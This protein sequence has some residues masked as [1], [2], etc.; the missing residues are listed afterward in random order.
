MK[1]PSGTHEETETHL[2]G[3]AL[4]W[5]LSLPLSPLSP[6]PL[7]L[8]R[9]CPL[10]R[11]PLFL[12]LSWSLRSRSSLRLHAKAHAANGTESAQGYTLVHTQTPGVQWST[13]WTLLACCSTGIAAAKSTHALC[14][15][16]RPVSAAAPAPVCPEVIVPVFISPALPAAAAVPVLSSAFTATPAAAAFLLSSLCCWIYCSCSGVRCCLTLAL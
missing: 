16:A 1:D 6:R 12:S 8:S 11:S 15:P 2:R 7:S 3:A 10:S 5:K 9:Y 13:G 14:P 4:F